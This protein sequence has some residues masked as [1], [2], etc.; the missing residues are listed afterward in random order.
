MPNSD[1]LAGFTASVDARDSVSV[2]RVLSALR[3]ARSTILS[4]DKMLFLKCAGGTCPK[5]IGALLAE[6]DY[7]SIA[8]IP[9]SKTLCFASAGVVERYGE[10]PGQ[11][12][13]EKVAAIR[14]G[15]IV[16]AL[17][18]LKRARNL[19]LDLRGLRPKVLRGR[20]LNKLLEKP[21]KFLEDSSLGLLS[22]AGLR[23]YQTIASLPWPSAKSRIP[24]S[25]GLARRSV[26]LFLGEQQT[27]DYAA[28]A[29]FSK[30]LDADTELLVVLW[31]ESSTSLSHILGAIQCPQARIFVLPNCDSRHALAYVLA[32]CLG[33]QVAVAKQTVPPR[34]LSGA[35]HSIDE[36]TEFV[37]EYTEF[38]LA[39]N[40]V[41]LSTVAKR[42][43]AA[44]EHAG[45]AAWL[46]TLGPGPTSQ[47]VPQL[48]GVTDYWCYSSVPMSRPFGDTREL[49]EIPT[50]FERKPAWVR[51]G[52]TQAEDASPLISVVMTVY[53]A[54]KTVEAALDSILQQT[55]SKL[56][57]FVVDDCSTDRSL[58]ILQKKAA[59]DSRV[60]VLQTPR[61]VGTYFAKNVGLRFARGA[62]VAFQDSDD[63]SAL[64][65]LELQASALISE[66]ADVGNF[67]RYQRL[68]ELGD[69]VWFDQ[70]PHRPGY[71]TLMLR[72]AE[73]LRLV[74]YFDSVRVAADTEYFDRLHVVTGSEVRLLPVVAYHAR[75]AEGSLT[76]SGPH[77][78]TTNAEG[79]AVMPASRRAYR[80]SAR[81]WHEEIFNGES[82]SLM[83]FPA[84]TRPFP[85]PEAMQP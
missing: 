58:A 45:L 60:R 14:K 4:E 49:S 78:F 53:N 17:P 28:L 55:H 48:E 43:T 50:C 26:V 19:A 62:F 37:V 64:H 34:S 32:R 9:A 56:E 22:G 66:P 8:K 38:F 83:P 76:T 44:S 72:R 63:V 11:S 42:G 71:I 47:V 65:R 46:D 12:I 31:A 13:R 27:S 84:S 40:V 54:E 16:S 61:N 57:V 23:A 20:K 7:Q 79:A 80:A 81:Q 59:E 5:D 85:A 24:S 15:G 39:P 30:A 75:H 29:R 74:G 10:D 82:S 41:W 52:E 35:F 68:S 2:L 69:A 33:G 51:R 25:D 67:T 1:K 3:A 70:A 6:W 77:A 36:N 21:E 18:R 73:A